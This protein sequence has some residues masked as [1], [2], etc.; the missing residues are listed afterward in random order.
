MVRV[1][2]NAGHAP[3]GNPDPGACGE[4]SRESDITRAVADIAADCLRLVGYEVLVVQDDDLQSV[5]D[6]S[7][8]FQ[9][10][11]FV[12][13]HCNSAENRSA[14]GTETFYYE[15]SFNGLK[16]A[17]YLQQQLI[18]SIENPVDR[19][20][21]TASFY[22]LR[23]TDAPAALVELE[24]ISNKYGEDYLNEHQEG[25]GRAIARGVSDY[26]ANN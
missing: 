13:I 19:G 7:D 11:V 9:A 5:C 10:D 25:L 21:K 26:F 14:R 15:G 8:G 24:F 22:V 18:D 4:Y 23:N 12:S 16:L 3:N 20:L 6:A 1:C 17:E 2:L